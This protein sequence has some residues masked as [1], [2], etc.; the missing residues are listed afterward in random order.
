MA[1]ENLVKGAIVEAVTPNISVSVDDVTIISITEGSLVVDYEIVLLATESARACSYFFRGGT[2]N[3]LIW[4]VHVLAVNILA[5]N[6][7]LP[8]LLSL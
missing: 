5:V 1:F 3:M 8:P 4:A 2:E 6:V 7:S